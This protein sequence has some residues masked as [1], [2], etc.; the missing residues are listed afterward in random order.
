MNVRRGKVLHSII[1]KILENSA[2]K[3]LFSSQ[4]LCFYAYFLL[5]IMYENLCMCN[6]HVCVCA[7]NY[8]PS[9]YLHI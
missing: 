3:K 1:V 9:I 4:T 8:L 5:N 6:M 2:S 7:H